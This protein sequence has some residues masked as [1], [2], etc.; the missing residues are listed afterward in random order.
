M[1][2]RCCTCGDEEENARKQPCVSLFQRKC[3]STLHSCAFYSPYV[4]S[5]FPS[6]LGTSYVFP[7][8]FL[9][10]NLTH[11]LERYTN[12]ATKD[13]SA[14]VSI[15]SSFILSATR[16]AIDFQHALHTRWYPMPTGLA[17][18]M[19]CRYFL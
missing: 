18:S 15:S 11:A 2:E 16:N 6:M 3:F 19:W 13:I 1:K 9:S 7:C 4:T 12:V 17:R 5:V 14:R 10:E 8:C